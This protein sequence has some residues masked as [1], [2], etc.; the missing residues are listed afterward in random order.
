MVGSDNTVQCHHCFCRGFAEAL[1]PPLPPR[2][3]SVS[4]AKETRRSGKESPFWQEKRGSQLSYG[5]SKKHTWHPA[6]SWARL[7]TPLPNSLVNGSVRQWC[8]E[9]RVVSEALDPSGMRLWVSVPMSHLHCSRDDTGMRE[10]LSG[11]EKWKTM[12]VA[13]GLKAS[14]AARP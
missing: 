3:C 14:A 4:A 1:R 9:P 7:G 13:S 2:P 8:S 12:D 5:Y 11:R 6:C 10:T